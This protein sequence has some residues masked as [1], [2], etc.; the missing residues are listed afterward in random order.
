MD[1]WYIEY[2]SR[3]IVIE[4]KTMPGSAG[5]LDCAR[6]QLGGENPPPTGPC[7]GLGAGSGANGGWIRG[8]GAGWPG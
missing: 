2:T 7:G 6:R 4:R 8:W 1:D 5:D 3:Y